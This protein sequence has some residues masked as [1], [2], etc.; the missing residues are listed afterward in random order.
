[1][2]VLLLVFWFIVIFIRTRKNFL[3]F[4]LLMSQVTTT[5]LSLRAYDSFVLFIV[6][7]KVLFVVIFLLNHLLLLIN[8]KMGI[9]NTLLMWVSQLEDKMEFV[10]MFSIAILLMVLFRPWR[11]GSVVVDFKEKIIFF[12]YGVLL[13]VGYIRDRGFTF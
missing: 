3:S 11:K 5:G 9:S 2:F 13:V 7:A 6:L 4:V 1:M 10:F 8:K 12:I